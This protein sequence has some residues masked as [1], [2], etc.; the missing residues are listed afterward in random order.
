MRESVRCL[1]VSLPPVVLE[2]IFPTHAHLTF[3]V[4]IVAGVL[5][6]HFIPPR[7]RWRQLYVLLALA[8]ALGLAHGKFFRPQTAFSLI[9]GMWTIN[10]RVRAILCACEKAE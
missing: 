9:L 2:H 7:G 6:Q 10:A 4:G 8:I 3:G 5:I 1:T